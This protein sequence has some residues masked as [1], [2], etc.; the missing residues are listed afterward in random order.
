VATEFLKRAL[1][2]DVAKAKE[3]CVPEFASENGIRE[4]VATGLTK[5]AL[6][7]VVPNPQQPGGRLAITE[8][9]RL[10][11]HR[12]KDNDPFGTG[13]VDRTPR[14]LNRPTI[15]GEIADGHLIL[16]LARSKNGEHWLVKDVEFM[17]AG[18]VARLLSSQKDE[19]PK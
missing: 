14:Q 17:D 15:K 18:A 5:P 16:S 7:T 2:N 8:R 19:K 10:F 11:I 9:A 13:T 1:A 4:L 3:L 12:E 6:L